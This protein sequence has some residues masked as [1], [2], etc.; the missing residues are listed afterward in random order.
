[1]T[2]PH[3]AATI[4]YSADGRAWTRLATTYV[5]SPTVV[6]GSFA[7]PGWYL[8]GYTPPAA[9]TTTGGGTGGGN[10]TV[11]VALGVAGGAAVAGVLALVFFRR[12]R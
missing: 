11:A 4:L 2:A 12:R 3:G 10:N 8:V 1:M 9:T 7:D 5:G 6:G